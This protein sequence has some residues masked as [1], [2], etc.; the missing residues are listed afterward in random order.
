MP[1]EKRRRDYLAAPFFHAGLFWVN[2]IRT[3]PEFA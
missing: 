2:S 1:K 3:Q